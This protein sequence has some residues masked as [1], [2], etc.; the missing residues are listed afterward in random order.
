M[1]GIRV[2]LPVEAQA[3]VDLRV[4]EI[5]GDRRSFRFEPL[6]CHSTST[7][8]E[9]LF[10]PQVGATKGHLSAKLATENLAIPIGVAM[11]RKWTIR[12]ALTVRRPLLKPQQASF[13]VTEAFV[14]GRNKKAF[15]QEVEGLLAQA[16]V[17]PEQMSLW[18]PE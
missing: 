6:H 4:A 17:Q 11:L 2:A 8:F 16:T 14:V 18:D 3:G 10:M 15:K 5:D 13:V 12:A 1:N 7:Q 9:D